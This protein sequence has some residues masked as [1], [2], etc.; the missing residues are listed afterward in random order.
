MLH[1]QLCKTTG[2]FGGGGEDLSTAISSKTTFF[3]CVFYIDT[4]SINTSEIQITVTSIYY[5]HKT[6]IPRNNKVET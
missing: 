3:L 6:V 4:V 1:I 5:K 2:F